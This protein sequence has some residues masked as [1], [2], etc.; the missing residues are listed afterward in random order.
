MNN[1]RVVFQYTAIY[2]SPHICVHNIHFTSQQTTLL[3]VIKLKSNTFS[4]IIK[5]II[6]DNKMVQ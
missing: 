4:L 2:T 1:S 6:Y 5:I 3:D